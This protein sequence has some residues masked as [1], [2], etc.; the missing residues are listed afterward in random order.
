MVIVS[1][2][3]AAFPGG[4]DQLGKKKILGS[5]GKWFDFISLTTPTPGGGVLELGMVSVCMPW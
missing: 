2:R 4:E 3:D 5:P 1:L